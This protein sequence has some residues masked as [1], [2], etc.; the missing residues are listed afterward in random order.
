[1]TGLCGDNIGCRGTMRQQSESEHIVTDSPFCLMESKTFDREQLKRPSDYTSHPLSFQPE[2]VQQTDISVYAVADFVQ[3][4]VFV[5]GVGAGGVAG[6][7][8]D[9]GKR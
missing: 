2:P 5:G 3:E 7:Y 1:M 8:L 9:R 6:A 4:D